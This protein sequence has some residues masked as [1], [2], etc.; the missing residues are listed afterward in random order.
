MT[1]LYDVTLRDGNHA[2]R[3]NLETQFV[4]KY[5]ALAN[6]S[7]VWAVEVG[8]GN[9][10]GASSYL[11]GKSKF[12]DFEL[13]SAAREQLTNTKLAVHS[14][15]G[16]STI[17]KDLSPAL[18]LGVDV[19]RVASHVTEA[20]ISAPHIEFLKNQNAIVQGV[21]MMSHMASPSELVKQC[22]LLQ[23]FGVDA[24]VL[25]DSAGYF[26]PSHV[27]ERI[28]LIERE[29]EVEIGIHAHNNLG[30]GVANA[31][32]AKEYGAT[33]L[34]GASMALGAGAGNAQLE[35]IVAHLSRESPEVFNLSKFMRMSDLVATVYK[36]NLPS[37]A[38]TSVASGIAGAF[39]GYAPF[40][41]LLAAEFSLD[42]YKLW[43]EVG[44]RKLVAGQ[45]SQLREIAME[46]KEK[47]A[48][49]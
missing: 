2:L 18:N 5:C 17:K 34:D 37:T 6:N 13:L 12:S 1:K 8:H 48:I 41:E 9:G 10:L 21:L 40:V 11:V 35:I 23:G 29:I 24:I 43:V 39:S 32:K 25:M 28:K 27:Q 49:E 4:T 30:V 7:G 44:R 16:F 33:F 3:H 31:L 15:P 46:V 20:N 42:A 26:D 45:E 22:K 47:E 36:S 19:F 14:M 38:S